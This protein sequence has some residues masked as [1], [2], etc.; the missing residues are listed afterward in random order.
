MKTP[1]LFKVNEPSVIFETIDGETILMNTNSGS[2][3]SLEGS[4]EVVWQYILETGNVKKAI[5]IM[6]AANRK[7]RQMISSSVT[8]FVALLVN[9]KLLVP[10]DAVATFS[11]ISETEEK[12]KASAQNFSPPKMN[13]YT[14]SQD[15]LFFVSAYFVK[16]KDWPESIENTGLIGV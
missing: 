12:L 3:F 15:I 10:S 14:D 1:T 6:T 13:K 8:E 16:E 7:I 5:R 4:G 9:E 11:G 2:F